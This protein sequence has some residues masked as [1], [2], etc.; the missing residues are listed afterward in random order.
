VK[1]S[2]LAVP[3]SR[4][5]PDIDDII[6]SERAFVT[7]VL[8]RAG[9]A[10][11][12]LPDVE[13][14]VF[15]VVH[16]RLSEFERRSSLRT[17]ICRIA[18]NLAS[19]YRRRACN[20]RE[21]LDELSGDVRVETAC[22]LER[23]DTLGCVA[24]AL[25]QLS[26]AKRE[27]FLLHELEELSMHDIA[28]RMQVPLK[29]AFSRLYGARRELRALL[30]REGISLGMMPAWWPRRLWRGQLRGWQASPAT[31]LPSTATIATCALLALPQSPATHVE[32][33]LARP[34]PIAASA[35]A[36]QP[37]AA[38]APPAPEVHIVP[39]RVPRERHS[40]PKRSR[41]PELPARAFV[42][43]APSEPLSVQAYEMSAEDMG[44]PLALPF[45]YEWVDDT[46]RPVDAPARDLLQ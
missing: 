11:R 26:E 40:A 12:D 36:S 18:L 29:T 42:A 21:S 23:R 37:M 38:V 8:S 46:S 19:E 15:L 16:R 13:Q 44:P 2:Q 24:S 22:P 30:L 43:E 7:R 1:P 10:E 6:R 3:G 34:Q 5:L 33:S 27:V 14:E 17:W 4:A 32:Q 25:D 45:G 41:S 39:A 31:W 20:R 35:K 28:R 9:V